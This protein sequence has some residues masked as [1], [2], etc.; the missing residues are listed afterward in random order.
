MRLALTSRGQLM[1]GVAMTGAKFTPANHPDRGDPINDLISRGDL[2]P[3][4]MEDLAA[5]MKAVHD[6]GVRYIHVHAR[7]PLT[8]EQTADPDIYRAIGRIAQQVAP[9]SL[10]SFGGSR[11]GREIHAAIERGGERARIAH[12]A[13]PLADG[14]ADFVTAQAAIELQVCTDFERQGYVALDHTSGTVSVLKPLATYRPSAV[15]ETVD[16]GVFSTAGGSSYGDSPATEQMN[17]L[18]WVIAQREKLVLPMEV[19][20]VQRLR[21]R[22]L[23]DYLVNVLESGRKIRRLNIT[24]LFGFSEPLPF[25]SSYPEFRAVVAEARSIG[26]ARAAIC[27]AEIPPLD[28]TVAVGAA[29]LPHHGARHLREIDVGPQTGRL[30]GPTERL[31]HWAC[32]FDSGVDI[33]R[34]GLEDAPFHLDSLGRVLPAT[35]P[36]LVEKAVEI[37]SMN[38][39]QLV[40]DPAAVA[41]F[42]A[43]P[44]A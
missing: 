4:S 42:G 44:Q 19:E 23:T 33:L 16:L 5:E 17:T 39:V 25:P 38:G 14:G 13:M 12:A 30:A 15:A 11:N 1:L 40:C 20:W 24:V 43:V 32:Q 26:E 3:T 9:G 29:I 41:E 10:L 22:V 34:I 21:S 2:V 18:R 35:N 27:N 28:V 7:N 6:M 37:V 36:S 8:R 31:A